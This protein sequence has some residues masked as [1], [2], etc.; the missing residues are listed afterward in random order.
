[1]SEPAGPPGPAAP[2]M[3]FDQRRLAAADLSR[4]CAPERWAHLLLSVVSAGGLL[5]LAGA[6]LT[7]EP[8]WKTAVTMFGP[9]GIIALS[10]GR[11]LTIWNQIASIL[12]GTFR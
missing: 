2:P 12:M 11:V 1:M 10:Q 8:D 4:H 6:L 5:I 7:R 3:T 9:A